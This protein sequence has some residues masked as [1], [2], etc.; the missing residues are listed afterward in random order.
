ML[1]RLGNELAQC[2]ESRAVIVICDGGMTNEC[3]A[4]H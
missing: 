3:F 4:A 2:T 1:E